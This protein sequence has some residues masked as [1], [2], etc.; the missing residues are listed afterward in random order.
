MTETLKDILATFIPKTYSS[1][2]SLNI[3]QPKFVGAFFDSCFS[4]LFPVHLLLN[5]FDSFLLE[6]VKIFYRYAVAIICLYKA[7]IK[8]RVFDTAEAFWET[9]RKD[10][11]SSATPQN[12]AFSATMDNRLLTDILELSLTNIGDAK[13]IPGKAVLFSSDNI[14]QIA[15]DLERSVTLKLLHPLNISRSYIQR[16]HDYYASRVVATQP[17]APTAATI[18]H[19]QP[20]QLPDSFLT[21]EQVTLL[22]AE[23]PESCQWLRWQRCY[24]ANNDGWDLGFV[25]RRVNQRSPCLILFYLQPPHAHIV[26]GALHGET[27]AP[28]NGKVRG[29]GR[30]NRVFAF[31]HG[32]LRLYP[33]L[34]VLPEN[35]SATESGTANWSSTELQFAV[36]APESVTFGGSKTHFSNALRWEASDTGAVITGYSDTY[37]NPPLFQDPNTDGSSFFRY[38]LREV[39]VYVRQ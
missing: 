27:L 34:G 26:L 38:S 8:A 2:V 28:L 17:I 31:E 12:A 20:L 15:F 22:G 3:I 21:A 4:S 10:A 37:A 7:Q 13:N 18:T 19:Q 32:S 11:L 1:L 14:K 24:A 33:W 23:L 16:K 9:V 25:Y 29:N 35:L 36:S 30:I 39:E 5:V 6:G